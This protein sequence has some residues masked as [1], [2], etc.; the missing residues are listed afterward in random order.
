MY[1][2]FRG[3]LAAKGKDYVALCCGGIGYK[4][5]VTERFCRMPR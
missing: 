4:L 3:E 5:F 2:Y 1:A